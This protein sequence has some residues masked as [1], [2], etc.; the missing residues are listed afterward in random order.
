MLEFLI[1]PLAYFE[2]IRHYPQIVGVYTILIL[3]LLSVIVLIVTAI[4]TIVEQKR[5]RGVEKA[6]VIAAVLVWGLFLAPIAAVIA[7]FALFG[8]KLQG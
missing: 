6:L 2:A 3:D 1:L 4:R 8:L 5:L 7:G